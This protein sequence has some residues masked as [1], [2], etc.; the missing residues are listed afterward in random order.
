MRALE[1]AVVIVRHARDVHEPFDVVL[2]EL[3]EQ[4]ERRDAGDVAFE[5][6]ADLVG[7][8]P[9]FLPLQELA[10]GFVRAPLHLRTVT[11]DFGQIL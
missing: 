1:K 2:G 11:R 6:I 3:H 4:P 10:L 5:F 8:E 7:H 9:H